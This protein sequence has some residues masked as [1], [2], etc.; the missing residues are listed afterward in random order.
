[1]GVV[2]FSSFDYL[3]P[4]RMQDYVDSIKVKEEKNEIGSIPITNIT[5]NHT[6]IR[7]AIPTT[8]PSAVPIKSSTISPT[9]MPASIPQSY[10]ITD[11]KANTT[12]IYSMMREDRSG[13]AL[14]DSLFAWAYVYSLD[15]EGYQYAGIC[16]SKQTPR[17]NAHEEGIRGLGLQSI[18]KFNCPPGFDGKNNTK[19][20]VNTRKTDLTN[21]FY[22]MEE[23]NVSHTIIKPKI[24]RDDKLLTL[25]FRAFVNSKRFP[26]GNDHNL[27]SKV[28]VHIRRG[29]VH[30][31]YER[32]YTPNILFLDLLDRILMDGDGMNNSLYTP[33]QVTIFS[34][35]MSFESFNN[36]SSR[37]Y[38]IQ[39]DGS[40]WDAW[41]SMAEA[42]ILVMSK[43]S[44]SYVP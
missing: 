22:Y 23:G 13:A 24:Y 25:A 34:E 16:P 21:I 33:E 31:C 37:G 18:L 11:S 8:S 9:S 27:R 38:N 5:T 32:R 44:F 3:V 28:A 6:S 30:P 7:T 14:H 43:S 42:E 20:A 39:L 10:S 19:T 41:K 4:R 29:D 26:R 35:S 17:I 1:M 36:F 2:I 40:L 15:M 12:M